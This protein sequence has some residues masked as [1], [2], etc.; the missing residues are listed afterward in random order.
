[1]PT[2]WPGV[3][4]VVLLGLATVSVP[5]VLTPSQVLVR[6]LASRPVKLIAEDA[7]IIREAIA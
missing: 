6:K 4:S 2:V 3:M 7:P 5:S 1:M